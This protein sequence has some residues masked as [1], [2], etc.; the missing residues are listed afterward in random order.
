MSFSPVAPV[1]PTT[2]AKPTTQHKS[3]F[4][5]ERLRQR[6]PDHRCAPLLHVNTNAYQGASQRACE[7]QIPHSL[8][9]A[10]PQQQRN[11]KGTYWTAYECG[12]YAPSLQWRLEW[13]RSHRQRLEWVTRIYNTLPQHIVDNESCNELHHRLNFYG[14]DR[15]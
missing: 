2:S 7:R 6:N 12:I 11:K 5:S 10:Q 3:C 13:K 9:L 15:C 4:S 1:A 14:K 8:E